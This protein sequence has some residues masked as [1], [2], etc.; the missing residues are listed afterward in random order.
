MLMAHVALTVFANCL[1]REEIGPFV[2]ND[3]TYLV[4]IIPVPTP[5]H[6]QGRKNRLPWQ[7]LPNKSP[8]GAFLHV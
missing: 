3:L 4:A 8:L 2:E 7:W 1:Q 6:Y 5:P